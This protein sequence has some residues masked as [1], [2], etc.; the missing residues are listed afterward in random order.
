MTHRWHN[1]GF[2]IGIA[3]ILSACASGNEN[4]S[5]TTPAEGGSGA[6]GA[7]GGSGAA[8][9]VG[10][11]TSPEQAAPTGGGAGAKTADSS[12]IAAGG[13]SQPPA[14]SILA[15]GG[16][17]PSSTPAAGGSTPTSISTSDLPKPTGAWAS[18]AAP[19]DK[20]A[21]LQTLSSMNALTF[22]DLAARSTSAM[23]EPLG[24]D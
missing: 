5:A 23:S 3:S 13:A 24:Y 8:T 7:A 16:A 21:Q 2:V 9:S 17:S 6:S 19:L 20:P 10:T 18:L 1:L 15:T 4:S 14:S 11:Q 12:A 22:D